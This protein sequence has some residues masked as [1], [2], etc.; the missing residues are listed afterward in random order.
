MAPSTTRA[1]RIRAIDDR[2]YGKRGFMRSSHGKSGKRGWRSSAVG[3]IA[4]CAVL[5]GCDSL[6]DVSL[7]GET[8]AAALD[9]PGFM[10]LLVTSAA[11][12]FECAFSN[13]ALTSALVAGEI[14]GAQSS[15]SMI[16]YQ[17]R[18]VRPLDTGF[19]EDG[20]GGPSGLYTPLATARFV[21]DDVLTKLTAFS[22]AE[23]PNR[24]GLMGQAALWAGFGYTVFAEGFCAAAFD[25]GPALPPA[26]VFALAKARFTAAIDLATQAGDDATRNA[27]LVGRARVEL[28]LGEASAAAADAALVPSGFQEVVTR[29]NGETA[30]QNDIYVQNVNSRAQSIDILF[31][32]Q[33]WMGVP[34]PRIDV[35]DTG[36]KGI[37][38]V[39]D[40]WIQHKYASAGSPIRLA[41]YT[42]A[43]LIV[44]EVAG[45]Q[46]AVD[47]INTLHAAAGLPSFS[48]TDPAEILAH[49]IEER[50][51]EFFLEGRRMGDLRHYGGFAA[52]AGGS[53]P[54]NGDQYGGTECF[55]IPD[56]ERNFNPN[57]S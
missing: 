35:T 27:A 2:T 7:P 9:T 15:L 16:P 44:A 13:Y 5:G 8:P 56:V 52:A 30:R 40:L 33:E 54:F 43:Q 42:E 11:G 25:L 19:G 17:R 28:Q 3:A 20:C 4:M 14:M 41:S 55:P 29:S 57:I 51:R 49:V 18:N 31:W 45:G 23:V 10:A 22:D 38:G 37:D 26:E 36:Q 12:D 48:S 32:N 21:A 46:T 53:H 24:G 47:I 6:L 1:D 39:T 50:R 34:D